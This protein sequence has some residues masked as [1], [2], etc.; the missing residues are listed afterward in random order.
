MHKTKSE[1]QRPNQINNRADYDGGLLSTFVKSRHK[2]IY[3][4]DKRKPYERENTSLSLR[5]P[6][7]IPIPKCEAYEDCTTDCL[8]SCHSRISCTLSH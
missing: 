5:F 8:R 4:C 2:I 6:L 7:E 1:T 3:G